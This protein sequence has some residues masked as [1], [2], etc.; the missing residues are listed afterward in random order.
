M[1][2]QTF[3]FQFV[4]N[5]LALDF[6]NT[7]IFNNGAFH[8]LF[9]SETQITSWLK[10]VMPAFKEVSF[11]AED[12]AELLKLRDAIGI[13]VRSSTENSRVPNQAIETINAHLRRFRTD[14]Q[15]AQTSAGFEMKEEAHEVDAETV[16]ATL[17]RAGAELLAHSDKERIKNCA[18][19]SCVLVF[20]DT[21]KSGRRRWCSMQT[22]GNRSKV[23]K[24]REGS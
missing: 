14:L 10:E 22:C 17:A 2:E 15:L 1:S 7:R 12:F 20:K 6:V 9:S 4:G 13:A 21:S 18:N 8:D 19:P 5:D 11:D 3:P 24:F 16:M 23:A